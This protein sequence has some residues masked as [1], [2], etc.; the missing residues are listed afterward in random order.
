[1]SQNPRQI[2][3]EIVA[4]GENKAYSAGA[5]I[6]TRNRD[7]YF[8]H[9]IRNGDSHLSRHKSGETHLI[10][11]SLNYKYSMGK[12]VPIENF[13]GI[14]FL[15]T[16]AFGLDSLPHLYSDYK[17][18]K[19]QG[20]FAVD[21]REYSTGS[22]NLTVAILT[23]EGLPKLYETWQNETKRQIYLYA[24]SNPMVGVVVAEIVSIKNAQKK[25]KSEVRAEA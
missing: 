13:T 2:R 6:I 8:T 3:I 19:C 9:N 24:N 22:F 11:R 7:V 4:L 5:V 23:E 21:M 10:S 12:R 17:L 16:Q 25:Q 15:G 18:K 20:I 1:M 14:E